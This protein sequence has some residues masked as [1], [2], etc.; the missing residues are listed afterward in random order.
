DAGTASTIPA[1]HAPVNSGSR[2]VFSQNL[3]RASA[4]KHEKAA[5]Q[6]GQWR[7]PRPRLPPLESASKRAG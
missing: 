5:R 4:K 7:T 6:Y 1:G 3:A 2:G